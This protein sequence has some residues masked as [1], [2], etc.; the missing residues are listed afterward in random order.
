VHLIVIV[1]GNERAVAGSVY[2][3][4]TLTFRAARVV[5]TMSVQLVRQSFVV[6]AP[7]AFSSSC[8]VRLRGG[9]DPGLAAAP[10]STLRERRRH[11]LRV[12]GPATIGPMAGPVWGR[13]P[14]DEQGA[15][16]GV[17]VIGIAS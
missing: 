15:S 6:V 14:S 1:I 9:S 13:G 2:I 8:G 16:S 17:L 11:R 3:T 7:L 4:S 5:Q 10:T 12:S